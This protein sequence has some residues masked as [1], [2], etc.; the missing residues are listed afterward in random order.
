MKVLGGWPTLSHKRIPLSVPVFRGREIQYLREAVKSTWVSSQGPFL[1]R[2]E[3]AVRDVMGGGHVV[4]VMNGT[5]ALHTA[6]M[7]AG[8]GLGDEVLVPSLTFVATAN[9]VTYCGAHPVFMDSD[10]TSGGIDPLKVEEF[11]RRECDRRKGT[12]IDRA[13]GR[14]VRALLPVHVLGHPVDMDALRVLARE[15]HLKIVED[16]CES[17]GSLYKGRPAGRL[18]DIS[19][20][21]FNGN[22]IVTSGGGGMVVTNKDSWARRARHLSTQAKRSPSEYIHDEIGYNYRM[23]N[24]QAALGLAQLESLPW[25]LRRKAEI[26]ARYRTAFEGA[27]GLNLMPSAPWARPN[28]WLFTVRVRKGGRAL[29]QHLGSHGIESR[30]LWRPLHR[31]PMYRAA[32]AYQIKIADILYRE[33]VSLPSSVDL[34]VESQAK[35]IRGVLGFVSRTRRQRAEG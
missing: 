14:P 19:C 9:A 30:L 21:S 4:A 2:F 5:S 23:T 34:S 12:T 6:L 8:V 16:A 11:L 20:L 27:S 10:E 18:G 3:A 13:T 15:F 1:A 22:K 26:E 29:V 24:I 31:L 28:H 33:A 17:L 25:F 35:V 7:V 32:R